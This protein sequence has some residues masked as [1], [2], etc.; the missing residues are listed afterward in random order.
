MS[1][2]MPLQ[3]VEQLVA[4]RLSR[5][6]TSTDDLTT[7]DSHDEVDGNDSNEQTAPASSYNLVE[8]AQDGA[9][10]GAVAGTLEY[11]CENLRRDLDAET[12]QGCCNN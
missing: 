5:A 10:P 1:D 11:T 6:T 8:V 2:G 9:G 3:G 4:I 7:L 12:Y